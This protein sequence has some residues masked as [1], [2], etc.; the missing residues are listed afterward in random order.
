[1]QFNSLG[2]K[3]DGKLTSPKKDLPINLAVRLESIEINTDKPSQFIGFSVDTNELVR[4]QMMTIEEG[5]AVNKRKGEDIDVT[6]ARL[7]Q[8]YVGTG[9]KHRPRASEIASQDHK[10]HCEAGGLLMF[11]KAMKDA[12]GVYRA[13]WVE[14]IERKAGAGCEKLMSHIRIEDIRSK[15]DPKIVVGKQIHADVIDLSKATILNSSNVAE[16][17][18]SAFNP[19]VGDEKL[20]PFIFVRLVD[21]SSGDIVLPPQVQHA[22]Y[23]GKEIENFDTGTKYTQYEAAEASDSITAL[24]GADNEGRDGAVIRA[25]LF[26][27]GGKEGYPEYKEG[28]DADL[29]SD[30]KQVT[31]LVRTGKLLV[32]VIPGQRISA[33][34][35]TKA[36]IIKAVASQPLNPINTVYSKRN[37]AGFTVERRFAETYLTTKVG[38]DGHRLFTKAVPADCF[39]QGKPLAKLATVNDLKGLAAA[40]QERAAEAIADVEV[41]EV[42][43]FD[44]TSLD[45]TTQG[46]VNDKL[47]ESQAA[48]EASM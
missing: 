36:S 31:D 16:T 44:P 21:A 27:L 42:G 1:M 46:D 32:E 3:N 43:P 13:H 15:E 38:K 11:T 25:A 20:K 22:S 18:K 12:N 4:V 45:G 7:Q 23:N 24:M 40:A 6:K 10:A 14:T 9:E 19:R 48:L 30:L 35:A 26:G 39:P 28:T 41:P 5:I 34:P 33:G 37:D 8:Q 2:K 29:L 17:L 47:I